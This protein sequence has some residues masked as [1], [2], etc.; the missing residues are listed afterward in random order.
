MFQ[1]VYWDAPTLGF[2]VKTSCKTSNRAGYK[3]AETNPLKYTNITLYQNNIDCIISMGTPLTPKEQTI[4]RFCDHEHGAN[5]KQNL[6]SFTTL[7][8]K[9]N[10]VDYQELLPDKFS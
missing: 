4:I 9:I 6:P 7:K 2:Y 3:R 5:V 8:P 10:N 1:I